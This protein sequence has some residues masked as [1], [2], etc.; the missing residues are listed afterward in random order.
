MVR[1][2]ST[3]RVRQRAL[4]KASK[5]PFLLPRRRT[6]LARASLNLAP[7][8]VPSINAA[9]DSPLEQTPP[10]PQSTSVEGR[11]PATE[12]RENPEASG[13]CTALEG[14]GS[15]AVE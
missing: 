9:A 5:W 13:R 1:R 6:N 3:V 10:G 2:G 8:P 15:R 11:F 4:K 12:E 7:K 14:P